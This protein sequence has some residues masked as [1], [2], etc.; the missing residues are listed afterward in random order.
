[1]TNRKIITAARLSCLFTVLALTAGAR[2]ARAKS[3]F[4]SANGCTPYYDAIQ[5]DLFQ[6]SLGRV[7][8]KSGATGTIFLVC[9]IT[10]PSIYSIHRLYL[11]YVDP[12]GTGSAGSVTAQIKQ[13]SRTTGAISD[14]GA[15]AT[16]ESYSQT[17]IWT[18]ITPSIGFNADWSNN[19]Y[20]VIIS[21]VRTTT[22]P[23]VTAFGVRIDEPPGA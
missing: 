1:M 5:Q 23:D 3:W 4:M 20:Y 6:N 15:A 2:D 8:F 11:T 18:A 22:S 16:S 17:T 21:I 10:D 19:F 13:V 9:S 7:K 12:T 14:I